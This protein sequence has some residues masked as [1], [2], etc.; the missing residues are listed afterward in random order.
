MSTDLTAGQAA[1]LCNLEAMRILLDEYSRPAQR[2]PFRPRGAIYAP[3]TIEPARMS[4]SERRAK[5]AKKAKKKAARR[6]R[7]KN[8]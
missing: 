1:A 8:R 6:A 4:K 3:P 2:A 5:R 7:R